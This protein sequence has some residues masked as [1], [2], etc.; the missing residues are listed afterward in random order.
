MSVREVMGMLKNIFG[1]RI[2]EGVNFWCGFA[3]LV[4]GSG[5]QLAIYQELTKKIYFGQTKRRVEN[6]VQEKN[7]W[8]PYT[9]LIRLFEAKL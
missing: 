1:F 6:R 2:F 3:G 8:G 4:L 7:S 9:I 5:L